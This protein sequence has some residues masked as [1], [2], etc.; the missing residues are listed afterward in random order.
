MTASSDLHS[1]DNWPVDWVRPTAADL[2]LL[3]ASYARGFVPPHSEVLNRRADEAVV[4][5][6]ACDDA[7]ELLFESAAREAEAGRPVVGLAAV[8]LGIPLRI[9]LYDPR[10]A[11]TIG[12]A[13]PGLICV[14]NPEIE[15]P[16]DAKRIKDFEGCL[17]AGQ[18]RGRT[19]RPDRLRLR[20]VTPRGDAVDEMVYRWAARVV[21]HE[22]DHLEGIRFP[23]IVADEDLGYASAED[24]PEYRT[25]V[26]CVR[27][28]GADPVWP[29][30][31]YRDQWEAIKSGVP[32][33]GGPT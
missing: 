16:S 22:Y 10:E 25:M 11:S 31:G 9:F 32:V 33:F 1:P 6:V 28:E 17:S 5:S 29:K 3:Q 23:D 20:G 15:V 4:G 30:P 26:Q 21:G 19:T 13:A 8:Q 18:F 27:D 24:T 2:E 14:V 12:T 7:V